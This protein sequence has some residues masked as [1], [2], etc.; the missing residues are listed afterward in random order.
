MTRVVSLK[1]NDA[2]AETLHRVHAASGTA[3]LSSHIKGVY[4]DALKLNVNVL[5]DIRAELDRIGEGIDAVRAAG[6]GARDSDL[7]LSV[8]CGLYLMVR[9]S[10]SES[11][12]AQADQM[13][14]AKAIEDYLRGA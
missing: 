9:K 6:Q 7:L 10:V 12:R 13:L 8:V 3:G 5:D 11:V 1:F 4:F 14:D 2:E